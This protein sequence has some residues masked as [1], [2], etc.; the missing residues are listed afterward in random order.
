MICRLWP[1]SKEYFRHHCGFVEFGF[2]ICFP[3]CPLCCEFEYHLDFADDLPQLP[4]GFNYCCNSFA[5]NEAKKSKPDFV[6]AFNSF[7]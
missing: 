4:V 1:D 5:V 2:G 6:N 3:F 7:H